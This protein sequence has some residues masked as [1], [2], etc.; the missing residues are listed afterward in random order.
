MLSRSNA[1]MVSLAQQC[2]MRT[3]KSHSFVVTANDQQIASRVFTGYPAVVPASTTA[4]IASS[5]AV[6]LASSDDFRPSIGTG[7][8]RR[9]RADA[10]AELTAIS[11]AVTFDGFT[12]MLDENDHVEAFP[13]GGGRDP[14]TLQQPLFVMSQRGMREKSR[15]QAVSHFEKVAR[16]RVLWRKFRAIGRLAGRLSTRRAEAAER[17]YAPGGAGQAQAQAEFEEAWRS[18]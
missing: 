14:C 17:A 1:E 5:D 2:M 11:R 18:L 13:F 15:A 6:S 8:L 7:E 16:R 10:L 9:Q 4:C 12:W 3:A